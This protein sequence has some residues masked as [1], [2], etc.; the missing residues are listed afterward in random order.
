MFSIPALMDCWP[1][2]RYTSTGLSLWISF[3]V[4][5]GSESF[6]VYKIEYF[7]SDKVV[8]L[9]ASAYFCAFTTIT[10]FALVNCSL[11]ICAADSYLFWPAILVGTICPAEFKALTSSSCASF[12][13]ASCSFSSETCSSEF[14]F[15]TDS[16]ALIGET[17]KPSSVSFLSDFLGTTSFSDS[18]SSFVESETSV[19]S[20]FSLICLFKSVDFKSSRF[21]SSF[22]F[23]PFCKLST[24]AYPNLAF[25]VN[26]LWLCVLID[27]YLALSSFST[28]FLS[29]SV[30][31]I[32]PV[33][34]ISDTDSA[35][36]ETLAISFKFF[37]DTTS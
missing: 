26:L 33:E 34:I 32:D 30:W 24:L 11:E 5:V 23:F 28:S 16:S 20:S 22:S 12:P 36:N 14:S 1:P 18:S 6:S 15:D 29:F 25:L 19:F 3:L 13:S 27:V 10:F 9:N 31:A 21:K 2:R 35:T 8:A 37:I 4:A 7:P 17:S